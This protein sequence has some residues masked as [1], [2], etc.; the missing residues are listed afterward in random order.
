MEKVTFGG[1]LKQRRFDKGLTVQ[2]LADRIRV[3]DRAIRQY[4]NGERVPSLEVA[5]LMARALGVQL[6]TIARRLR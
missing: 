3:S 5:E 6:D 4:E 1:W 2:Q